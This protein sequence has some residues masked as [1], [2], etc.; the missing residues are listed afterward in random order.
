[1][2]YNVI[3][4]DS[5]TLDAGDYGGWIKQ[6]S[7]ATPADRWLTGLESLIDSL[8]EMPT[9]FRAIDE[10]EDF[11]IPLRQVPY[12][13]HR[14]IYHVNEETQTVHVLRVYHSAQKALTKDDVPDPEP[15]QGT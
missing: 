3:I 14:V 6:K 4:Q 12:H 7:G 10:Q 8:A 1:M 15:Q 2:P 13:S 9:R 11:D 5:A